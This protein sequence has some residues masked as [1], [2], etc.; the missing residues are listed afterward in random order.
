MIVVKCHD[1]LTSDKG[2]RAVMRNMIEG[3]VAG[4]LV[5]AA[6][7]AAGPLIQA[8]PSVRLRPGRPW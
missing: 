8:E 2:M 6:V 7:S 1:W 3:F 4:L 5:G